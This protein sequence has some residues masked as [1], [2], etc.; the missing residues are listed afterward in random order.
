VHPDRPKPH[1]DW[2][3]MLAVFVVINGAL[4]VYSY[5][6]LLSIMEAERVHEGGGVRIGDETFNAAEL[7]DIA[8]Y[9]TQKEE[10]YFRE[11]GIALPWR[12]DSSASS[13][14]DASSVSDA[15]AATTSSEGNGAVTADTVSQPDTSRDVPDFDL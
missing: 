6:F 10:R 12:G 1:R 3:I 9:Y 7:K 13:A 15:S 8:A 14:G 11:G 4:M 2:L 5:V